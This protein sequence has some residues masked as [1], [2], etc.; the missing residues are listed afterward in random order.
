MNEK[1][2]QI[3]VLGL[4]TKAKK[5]NSTASIDHKQNQGEPVQFSSQTVTLLW[6]LFNSVRFRYYFVYNLVSYKLF[7]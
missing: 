5:P 4:F 2:S 7:L 6:Q 3:E 1:P